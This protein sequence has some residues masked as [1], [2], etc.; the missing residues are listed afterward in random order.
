[1][2]NHPSLLFSRAARLLLLTVAFALPQKASAEGYQLPLNDKGTWGDAPAQLLADIQFALQNS[3]FNAAITSAGN[4][5]EDLSQG[6][7]PAID[8][9]AGVVEGDIQNRVDAAITQASAATQ[10]LGQLDFTALQILF[11]KLQKATLSDPTEF[12]FSIPN[13]RLVFRRNG[14]EVSLF[15]LIAGPNGARVTIG[16]SNARQLCGNPA[17]RFVNPLQEPVLFTDLALGYSHVQSR[18]KLLAPPVG[19][20]DPA[21]SI[22]AA[23]YFKI[24]NDWVQLRL[25]G[26]DPQSLSLTAQFVVGARIGVSAKIQAEVEGQMILELQVKPNQA[27]SMLPDITDILVAGL[28]TSPSTADVSAQAL[29]PVLLEVFEYLG[30]ADEGDELGEISISFA[31]DGGVGV[32]IWDT[33]INFASVGAQTKF[34]VP[35]EATVALTGDL[36]AAFIEAGMNS[37]QQ[38]VPL[39]EAMSEGRLDGVELN[40]QRA[41]L[42][43]MSGFLWDSINDAFVDFAKDISISF[44]AGIYALGDIGQVSD[45]TIPLLLLE[46][47]IPIGKIVANAIDRREQFI[48]ACRDT[49]QALAWFAESAIHAGL[50]AGA[51]LGST[52]KPPKNPDGYVQQPS[53][54]ALD[55]PTSA[56]WKTI[57]AGLLDDVTF[58][59][60]AYTGFL[61]GIAIED[62]SLGNF[63]RLTA[64][65]TET[66]QTVLA[67]A[68]VAALDQNEKPLLDALRKALAD[69]QGDALN[70]LIFNLKTVS[71]ASYTS[72]GASGNIGAEVGGSIGARVAFEARLKASLILLA[73]NNPNYDEEDGTILAGVDFPVEMS[74]SLGVSAGEIAEVTVEGGLTAGQSLA[75]LTLKDWGQDLPVPA[76]LTVAGFE[77]IDFQG[78]ARQDGSI[79]GKGWIV[80]PMGGL[81]RG[82]SFSVAPGGHVLNGK[83]SGVLELGPFGQVTVTGGT[84]TDEGLRG[85]FLMGLGGSFLQAEFLLRSNG[86]LF[87]NATGTV[88]FGGIEFA[89]IDLT[90]TQQGDFAGAAKFN[91]NGAMVDGSLV[92]SLAPQANARFKAN[93]LFGDITAALD[94]PV[95]SSG[96]SGTATVMIFGQP[97]VFDVQISPDGTVTGSTNVDLQT[98][99]GIALNVNLILDD[100]GVHGSGQTRILGSNFTASNLKLL[101]SGRLTGSFDGTLTVDGK[102][103]LVPTLEILENELQGRTTIDIVGLTAVEILLTIDQS[104]VNG[105]FLSDLNLFGAGSAK[106][107]LRI[108][109]KI[110]VYGEMDEAFLDMLG[111]LLRDKLV[112][113]IRDAQK[114]VKDQGE[115]IDKLRAEIDGFDDELETLYNQ[116]LKERQDAQKV[117]D[118]AQADWQM[119]FDDLNEVLD[120]IIDAR[121]PFLADLKKFEDAARLAGSVF[122][123]A[124][125]E[126]A[127]IDGLIK[128]LDDAYNS[129]DAVGKFFAKDGYNLARAGLIKLRDEA[130]KSLNNAE[131]LYYAALDDLS[132]IRK[133]IEDAE[134]PFLVIKK[135]K[136][137]ALSVAEAALNN[138]KSA[139]DKIV[140]DP[141]NDPRYI[142][143][144]LLRSGAYVALE[145]AEILLA[146]THRI[147]DAVAVL[148]TRI[149]QF[150]EDKLLT[151]TKVVFR[152]QLADL[153]NGD[154][155]LT[156]DAL[157]AGNPVTFKI[158]YNFKTGQNDENIATGAKRLSPELYPEPQQPNEPP[159][160]PVL[161]LDRVPPVSYATPPVGWRN[162][163]VAFQIIAIDLLTGVKSIHYSITGAQFKAPTQVPGAAVSVL[164]NTPGISEITWFAED[165]AG[166]REAPRKA[167]VKVDKAGPIATLTGPDTWR[168]TAAQVQMSATD[169]LS[170]VASLTYKTTG[171]LVSGPVTLN[172]SSF[173]AS[174]NNEGET[175]IELTARDI[176]GNTGPATSLTVRIDQT[177]PELELSGPEE[178]INKPAVVSIQATDLPSGIER[179]DVWAEGAGAFA[180]TALVGSNVTISA[181]GETTVFAQARDFAGNLSLIRSVTVRIDLT[182]PTVALNA[183][184]EW[185]NTPVEVGI[186]A[187]DNPGGSGMDRI[188]LSATGAQAMA[189]LP[190]GGNTTSF[191]FSAEGISVF[192]ATPIDIAG[193]VGTTVQM[194]IRI[195]LTAPTITFT[196]DRTYDV[197]EQVILT[198]LAED[199]LSGI[200][201]HN[202]DKAEVDAPAYTFSVGEHEISATATDFAGNVTNSKTKFTVNVSYAGL[203]TLVTRFVSPAGTA[204]ALL[205]K[206]DASRAASERGQA[207]A[208]DNQ[209]G[210]FRNLVKAQAGKH[211]PARYAAVLDRLAT[212]MAANN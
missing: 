22:Q 155:E 159:P 74:A 121:K 163:D 109:D 129:L 33:G 67:G 79:D 137:E 127:R 128:I 36:L 96:G 30:D 197:A 176:A 83:W 44:E 184:I 87:G 199:A 29:A 151:L 53:G 122:E 194:T 106:A 164:F 41:R 25:A 162:T 26:N 4:L 48:S 73:L 175:T 75:N 172:G 183:P 6:K 161:G 168:S 49:G 10:L 70:L 158:N 144:A 65:T 112:A 123:A 110:E 52:I 85:S 61:T 212:D 56:D 45:Q 16:M 14:L 182:P 189:S 32:G 28:G 57:S 31:V 58:S 76:G 66:T 143:V 9:L 166:N 191:P 139:L 93:A 117:F 35:L 104:G 134:A 171:A 2:Q 91:I 20:P 115:L 103:M 18:R 177:N 55:P 95:D 21:I 94:L 200:A 140:S 40:A 135:I 5:A 81:V 78:D 146:A 206:L 193:N 89:N 119:A 207:K 98:P 169:V 12:A 187:T 152:S 102:A 181:E 50:Q 209:L 210:A 19:F 107:R 136:S 170:G 71:I 82:D 97:V 165:N 43:T 46:A 153:N 72:V 7:V 167:L 203:S 13:G 114:T 120:D 100:T 196:G 142:A 145:S 84:I 108:T 180:K 179:I 68:I 208:A 160:P 150:G 101:P 99:W 116:I 62:I 188:L 149:E 132:A 178:W 59:L 23:T 69:I 205:A 201:S 111:G 15:A 190:V 60:R 185:K 51:S 54:E 148:I 80:L 1:M 202:C 34:S 27:A 24:H 118:D 38:F 64:T 130:I 113:S 174:F 124:R 192:S 131:K 42:T 195:D 11:D 17:E 156:I 77:V 133:K 186:A 204:K 86:L 90:L 47:D 37:S 126:V 141:T 211:I 88:K 39:F 125:R 63:V 198:C 3:G 105:S 154:A 92:I 8:D 147:L 173:S 157:L 138:A